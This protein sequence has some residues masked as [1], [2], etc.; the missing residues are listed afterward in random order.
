MSITWIVVGQRAG[1]R[2]LEQKRPGA[3][4]RLVS[5]LDHPE[6]RLKSGEIDSDKPGTSF[7]SGPGPGRHPMAPEETSHDRVVANFAREL[8]E[9]LTR[10]RNEHRFDQLV[11]V[12]EPRFFGLL[13]GKL[14][15]PTAAMLTGSLH[16]DLAHV[17]IHDL[18]PLLQGVLPI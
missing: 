6:G 3:D 5:E 13:R 15:D 12:A 11:L 16:K 10:A 7:S 9:V 14:D 4:L 17:P 18:G 8:A 1:A 2:I